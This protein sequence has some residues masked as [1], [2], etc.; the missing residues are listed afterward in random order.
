V[1]PAEAAVSLSGR[2]RRSVRGAQGGAEE[3]SPLPAHAGK[4]C[5]RAFC[6]RCRRKQQMAGT[7]RGRKTHDT[8]RVPVWDEGRR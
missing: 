1:R 8:P 2:G 3:E 7:A 6:A 4:S 5:P